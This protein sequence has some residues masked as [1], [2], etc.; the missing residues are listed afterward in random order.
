M[1]AV[2]FAFATS[3]P[4]LGPGTSARIRYIERSFESGRTAITK[5]RTPI[6]PMNM[7][8][9]RQKPMPCGIADMPPESTVAPVVV[10]PE[11]VSKTASM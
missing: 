5:T 10:K 1:S 4:T 7:M 6:P 8:K 2:S 3:L 11:A 9:H